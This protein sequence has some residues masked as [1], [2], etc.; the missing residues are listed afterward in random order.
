MVKERISIKG[1]YRESIFNIMNYTIMVVVLFLVIIPLLNV[2]S[3]SMVSSSEVAAKKYII[4][5]EHFDFGAYKA[6]LSNASIVIN[7]YII[8]IF[9]VVAG[10][11]ASMIATY[12]LAYGLSIK[13][14]PFRNAITVFVFIPMLFSGGLIPYYIVIRNLGLIN[15]L[16]VYILPILISAYNTLLLRNFIMNIPES[17]FESAQIDGAGELNVIFRIVLPLML[18]AMAT[19]G[20]FYAVAQWN[21][22]FDAYLFVSKPDLQPVQLVLRNI[23]AASQV[24]ITKINGQLQHFNMNPPPSRAIQNAV[25]VVST[26][27]IVLIYPFVQKYFVKGI[28][29]GSIKG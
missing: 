23:L 13:R 28:M 9:R 10:T 12:F 22:W 2:I 6:I 3:I 20:L 27:P 29:V 5:P 4:F 15:N 25:I 24:S 19:I 11:L 14:L 8:T 18:P 7:A 16:L 17:I 1:K 26:V 21:S